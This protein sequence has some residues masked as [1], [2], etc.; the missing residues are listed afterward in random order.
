LPPSLIFLDY[1]STTPADPEVLQVML[2]YFSQKFGN[3]SSV[4]HRFG[5]EADAA[6]ALAREQVASLINAEP[7]EIF[8]TSGAT[9]AANWVISGLTAGKGRNRVLISAI[10][11]AAVR[12]PVNRLETS[13]FRIETI[14]VTL[15]GIV[16]LTEARNRLSEP[17]HLGCLMQVNNETG[18]IQPV[19]EFAELVKTG[20][21]L[22]LCDA[23]QAAGKIP[24]DVKKLGADFLILSSHKLYGPKGAGCLWISPGFKKS[25]L[26]PLI[27]GGGQESGFRGGTL[28]VPAIAGFGKAAELAR[29]RLTENE[30]RL[31]LFRN[32]IEETLLTHFPEICIHGREADRIPGTLLF[33]LGGLREGR[34][35][36]GLKGLAVSA[37]SACASGNQEPSH[38]LKAMK[39]DPDLARNTI[40]ISL[41]H[42]VT[43]AEI[44]DTCNL[45]VSG[46]RNLTPSF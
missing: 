36:K 5:L 3:P 41:G 10:E 35:L 8:F 16:N 9:E 26:R 32:R 24:V 20:G 12:E 42:P 43:E 25:G 31:K 33:S 29:I 15:Q 1:N 21:G 37:G 14:G 18:V 39:V 46:I 23:V 19:E 34:L 11:H 13:G 27:S 7:E 44:G 28:N 6:V 2:P 45:L 38:V 30:I 4:T 22:I 40:R 17:V